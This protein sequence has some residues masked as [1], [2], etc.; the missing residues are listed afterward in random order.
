[1]VAESG[2]NGFL[3]EVQIERN[4]T[5]RYDFS[6]L[7]DPLDILHEAG[8][9]AVVPSLFRNDIAG[10]MEEAMVGPSEEY[11]KSH[12]IMVPDESGIP[13]EDPVIR[14]LLQCGE[15]E[16]QAWAYAAAVAAGA[17]SEEAF[18]KLEHFA[19]VWLTLRMHSHPGINGLIASGMTTRP[20]FP[21]M[22]RWLQN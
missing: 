5:I 15:S 1:M 21:H 14:G 13:V 11:I 8:H 18:S 22:I 17:A 3:P 9:V 6:L 7:S 12:P 19:D 20:M 2:V 10:D 16:A 4:M